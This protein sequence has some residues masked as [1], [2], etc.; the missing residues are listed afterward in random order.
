MRMMTHIVMSYNALCVAVA[1]MT[2]CNPCNDILLFPGFSDADS[3]GYNFT[4]GTRLA[5]F[6]F[7]WL[8]LEGIGPSYGSLR[9]H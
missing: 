3:Q 9:H 6:E 1:L 8:S 2:N 7:L 5:P 4:N